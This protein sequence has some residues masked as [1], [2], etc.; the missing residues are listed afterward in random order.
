MY[1][2]FSTVTSLVLHHTQK[3]FSSLLSSVSTNVSNITFAFTDF[4]LNQKSLDPLR[5]IILQAE[6]NLLSFH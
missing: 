1:E 4:G 2:M 3:K 5:I 6:I